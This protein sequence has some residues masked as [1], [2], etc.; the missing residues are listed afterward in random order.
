[1]KSIA[2][3]ILSVVMPSLNQ[4][5]YLGA[6]VRSVMSQAV[7]ALELV[8][9]DGG[10][11]DGS[12]DLLAELTAESAGRLRWFSAP[13]DGAAQAIHSAILEA[14][15]PLIGWLNSDDL[16]TA[17]AVQRAIEHL[18]RQPHQVMVYGRGREQ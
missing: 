11:T 9:M 15:A 10:S 8:V 1:M 14:R 5:D 13:D 3:P 2:S 18:A 7:E 12:L 4:H 6:A 16:Y 17:G